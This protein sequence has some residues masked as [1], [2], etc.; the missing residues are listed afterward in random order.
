MSEAARKP[1]RRWFQFS[2]GTMFAVTTL[3]A[4]WL[5][6]ELSYIRKRQEWIRSHPLLVDPHYFQSL[7]VRV[8][9]IPRWRRL[10]G[11]EAVPSIAELDIWDDD[12]RAHIARLFP[13]AELR[14]VT[15]GGA[16]GTATFVLEIAPLGSMPTSG[17]QLV[18][19]IL[20]PNPST[21]PGK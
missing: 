20:M 19:S 5:A 16:A 11:D 3:V 6:W 10:L 4:V 8:A 14:N 13:E 21:A 1:R 12:D 15:T 17:D 7:P 2:L 9:R 18:P